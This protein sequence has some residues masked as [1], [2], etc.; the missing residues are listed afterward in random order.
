MYTD[1]QLKVIGYILSGLFLN[2]GVFKRW[3]TAGSRL[4]PSKESG[5]QGH[6]VYS[7]TLQMTAS[8]V[9]HLTK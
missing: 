6:H 8:Q 2:I 3:V 5:T 4:N 7:E 1:P 9:T